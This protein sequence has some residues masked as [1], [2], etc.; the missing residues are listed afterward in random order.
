MFADFSPTMLGGGLAPYTGTYRPNENL[1]VFRGASP[2]GNWVLT[3]SD[4]TSGND[5]S[6][7]AWSITL[8]TDIVLDVEYPENGEPIA[9]Y[10]LSQ[11]YPNPFNPAT[12]IRYSVPRRSDV[13]IEVFNVLGRKVLTLVDESKPLG[14]YEVIWKGCDSHGNAVTTGVYLYRIQAG[15]FSETK[16]MVLMR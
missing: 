5:G 12:T 4:G 14:E 9:S 8:L 3:V 16:K 10:E 2:N 11:C 7:K 1:S 15:A 13:V 6:L